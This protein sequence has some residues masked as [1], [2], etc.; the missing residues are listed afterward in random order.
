MASASQKLR[1]GRKH[2]QVSVIKIDAMH[3][4]LTT[5]RYLSGN[6]APVREPLTGKICDYHGEIPK[7]LVGGQYI[8]N[9]GN[10]VSNEQAD[11][12][13]H[14]FDGDGMLA[15]IFFDRCPKD[16]SIQ[17]CFANQPVLTAV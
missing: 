17:P 11:R 3:Y 1:K 12:D 6:F 13:V 8:R 5:L 15:G 10:P 2:P 4:C 9:G 16:G 14:W 7:D